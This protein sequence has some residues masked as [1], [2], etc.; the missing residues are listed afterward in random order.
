MLTTDMETT[1]KGADM[2]SC[3]SLKARDDA[4]KQL[5]GD[6]TMYSCMLDADME[7]HNAWRLYCQLF[8]VIKPS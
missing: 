6:P 7:Y 4:H 2:F 3:Q 1:W 5:Q 8:K